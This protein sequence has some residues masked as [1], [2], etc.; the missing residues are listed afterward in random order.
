MSVVTDSAV[1][2]WDSTEKACAPDDLDVSSA[3]SVVMEIMSRYRT[4]VPI[5]KLPALPP[6]PED[7]RVRL[8]VALAKPALQQPNWPVDEAE[9]MRTVLESVPPISV[10]F[11]IQRLQSQLADVAQGQQYSFADELDSD[12]RPAG[13]DTLPVQRPDEGV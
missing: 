13:E 8:D 4:D 12:R 6:L 3:L 1:A 2:L 10:P 11:E 9:A 7:L 5:D